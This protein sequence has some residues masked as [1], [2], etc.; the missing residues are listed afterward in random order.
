MSR[1]TTLAEFFNLE[2]VK[3]GQTEAKDVLDSTVHLVIDAHAEFADPEMRGNAHTD[4]VAKNIAA[5]APKFREL[6]IPT[7]WIHFK[8]PTAG[9]VK[10]HQVQPPASPLSND[11]FLIGGRGLVFLPDD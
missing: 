1:P 3:A 11:Q 5:L 9:S 2:A 6:N 10:W 4:K 7:Y 8:K